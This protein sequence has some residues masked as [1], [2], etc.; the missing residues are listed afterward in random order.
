MNEMIFGL[1]ILFTLLLI[2]GL[3]ITYIIIQITTEAHR[4]NNV[5]EVNKHDNTKRIRKRVPT[6]TTKDI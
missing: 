3:L 4:R 1:I 5:T 2:L 6:N